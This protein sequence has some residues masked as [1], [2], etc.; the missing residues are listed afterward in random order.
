MNGIH[1]NKYIRRWLTGSTDITDIVPA[2]NIQPLVIS[3]TKQPFITFT[4]GP[5]HPDYS[6]QGVVV[7]EVE[8]AIACVSDDYEQSIDIASAVRDTLEWQQYR[9]DDI[10]I[11]DITFVDISED[12]VEDMYLQTLVIKFQ[13]ETLK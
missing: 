5:I 8:V 9:D 4:H 10:Y 2:K 6:K 3:P 11:P 12:N 1:I 13:I 7:D